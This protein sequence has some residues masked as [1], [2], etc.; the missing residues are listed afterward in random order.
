MGGRMGVQWALAALCLSSCTVGPDYE[1]PPLNVPTGFKSSTPEEAR[2][3]GLKL[4]WWTL[5]G[6]ATLTK[7]EEQAFQANQDL[8]AA[9][10][11]VMEARAAA[12][13]A[14]A[15]YYPQVSFNPLVDRSKSS[16]NA[17]RAQ[18]SSVTATDIQAPF[19]L[20]YQVDLW[21]KI[22][23]T[24]ESA[25]AQAQASAADLGVVLQT[26]QS[27]LAQDYFTL[28]SLDDQIQIVG[29]NVDS[30]Q[31]ELSLLQTQFKAGLVGRIN[32]VQ[33]EAQLYSTQTQ[34]LE[35]Q[36]QRAD[37]EHAVATLT[38]RPPSELSLP[39]QPLV[40]NPPTIPAG[41]PADLLRRR[42]DVAEAE[43][44]LT[45][46]SAQ[47]GI[48]QAAFYPNL[49]LTATGGFEATD[50]R[51]L[52]SWQSRIWSLGAGA[53]VPIFQGGALDAGLEQAKAHYDELLAAYRSKVLQ[54]FQDVEDSLTDLHLRADEAKA[55]TQAANSSREYFRLAE[56]QYQQGLLSYLQVIDA[57]RT[58]LT[59]ELTSSQILG[60]RFV[61]TVQLIKAL[62]AGWD[63]ESLTKQEGS[64]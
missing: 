3:P 58:L 53:V 43:Q 63:I 31:H 50:L 56:T 22:R 48:A 20:S 45:A 9:M 34:L 19:D 62:G 51:H 23:R 24:V 39:A 12:R 26:I 1:R 7:L 52:A 16:P 5:F 27:D 11:R 32:V 40:A 46:A 28:R 38:G 47:I 4:D 17:P 21:G 54:A 8:K 25:D 42:P 30:Y 61:S 57:E 10:A 64:P 44:N 13:I 37:L 2:Q 33:E 36:R 6:D 55:Q 59:N 15:G 49:T 18:G 35:L 41:L 60:Q 29:R 14:M